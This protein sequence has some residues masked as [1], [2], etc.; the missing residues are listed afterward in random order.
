MHLEAMVMGGVAFVLL[1]F[2]LVGGPMFL[3]DWLRK[4]RE[5]II[6]RQI[7]LT[8]AL[9]EQ[10][11]TIVAA[12][13][14]HPL[15]GPWKIQIE[16]PLPWLRSATVAGILPLVDDVF[17]EVARIGSHSYRIILTAKAGSLPVTRLS[18]SPRPTKR[19][20][21]DPLAVA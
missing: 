10:L 14:T 7:A 18:R 6:E 4:R 17:S 1:G 5:T 2:V 11:G 19:W 8:D 13:V 12:V 21:R 3:V 9:D 16:V 15:F 20:A